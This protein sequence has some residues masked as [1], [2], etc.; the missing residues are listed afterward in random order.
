LDDSLLSVVLDTTEPP[1]VSTPERAF[2]LHFTK[3]KILLFHDTIRKCL[4][5]PNVGLSPM[6]R[7]EHLLTSLSTV[8]SDMFTKKGHHIHRNHKVLAL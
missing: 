7:G 6:E 1:R 3:D 5:S 4:E 2:W 8:S